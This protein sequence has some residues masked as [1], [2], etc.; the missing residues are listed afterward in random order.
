MLGFSW[1]G[2][3]VC[4]ETKVIWVFPFLLHIQAWKFGKTQISWQLRM[5]FLVQL[6]TLWTREQVENISTNHLNPPPVSDCPLRTK[7]QAQIQK[8]TPNYWTLESS[9]FVFGG[10]QRI[11]GSTDGSPVQQ[12]IQISTNPDPNDWRSQSNILRLFKHRDVCEFSV[13]IRIRLHST[14]NRMTVLHPFWHWL[15]HKSRLYRCDRDLAGR[16]S[17]PFTRITAPKSRSSLVT[18][19]TDSMWFVGDNG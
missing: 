5:M 19:I 14:R 4:P 12:S 3:F 18:E 10:A 2:G 8:N 1:Q 13:W 16:L 15:R 6:A 7:T 9:F 11:S 17:F